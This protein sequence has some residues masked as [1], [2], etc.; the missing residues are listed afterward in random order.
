MRVIASI[1]CFGCFAAAAHA[2]SFPGCDLPAGYERAEPPRP[3]V[4]SDNP[5]PGP[6]VRVELLRRGF[7]DGNPRSC[8]NVGVL[9]LVLD[10]GSIGPTE[11]YSFEVAGGSLPSGL[12]PGG[13]VESVELGGNQRGFRFYWLDLAP[14]DDELAPLNGV[15]R[16]VRSTFAGVRSEPMVLNIADP[17]GVPEA[18]SRGW[19]S[20]S[21]WIGIALVLLAFVSMRMKVFRRSGRRRDELAEIQERLRALA[22]EKR[23]DEKRRDG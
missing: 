12:L 2:Q 15:I 5:D 17:G 9:T 14:D 20:T 7:D 4:L 1:L 22:D 19:N 10:P 23:A 11:V 8:S 6:Q 13:Y 16:I 3:S 21:I 18:T